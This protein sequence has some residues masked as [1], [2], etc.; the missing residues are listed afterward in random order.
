MNSTDST[1]IKDDNSPFV[2]CLNMPRYSISGAF[3]NY[4]NEILT[5]RKYSLK[6]FP[7]AADMHG[8][9]KAKRKDSHYG[10]ECISSKISQLDGTQDK[11]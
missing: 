10:N 1:E 2:T 3:G 8:N 7:M 6:F 4:C 5:K 11:C 9:R